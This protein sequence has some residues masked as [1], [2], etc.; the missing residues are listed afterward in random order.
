[1]TRIA[2]DARAAVE[3]PAGRGRVLRELLAALCRRD[4]DHE[5]LLY[6]RSVWEEPLDDRF[7]WR[8]RSFPD[9]LWNL[10]AG[11]DA[12]RRA[13]VFLSTNSYL[14][15]WVTT[16][17][18]VVVVYDTVAWDAPDSAQRRAQLIERATIRPALR[19]AAAAICISE[20]TREDLVRRFPV[21]APKAVVAPLAASE[22][23][24]SAAR[25]DRSNFVLTVGTLEPR[26]NLVRAIEAHSDL[27]SDLRKAHPLVIAGARGWERDEILRTAAAA[28]AEVRIGISDDELAELYA[29]CAVFLFPSLYE[30]FGL[31]LLEAMSTGA[32]AV[33]SGVSS[34]PEVG[35]DAVVYVDP[36]NVD[37]IRDGLAKLLTDDA[38]RAELSERAR[39]RSAEFSWDRTAATLLDSLVRA[40]GR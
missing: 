21:A 20:S 6:G 24:R 1:V 11:V 12:S 32:P 2:L 17:P 18:T 31:P 3:E 35:G 27:P 8:L 16:V 34:L 36:T 15:A 38:E 39:R 37:A 19:R 10:W 33:T 40:A 22:R 23:F 13:E 9:P 5:Y 29:T 30:G 28:E 4:D 26:K 14:T 25:S 7:R